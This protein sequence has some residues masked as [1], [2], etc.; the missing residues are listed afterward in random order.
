[1]SPL[2]AILFWVGAGAVVV[3]GFRALIAE[4]GFLKERTGWPWYFTVGGVGVALVIIAGL[5]SG[6]VHL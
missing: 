3:A 4:T 2:A 1:M 6:Q 5:L